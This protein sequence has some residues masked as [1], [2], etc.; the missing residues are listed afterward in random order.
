MMQSLNQQSL[1]GLTLF[2]DL[3][4]TSIAELQN[5][6]HSKKLP[7]ATT[8]LSEQHDGAAVYILLHG[9]VK[10]AVEPSNGTE[11]ILAICGPGEV[12]GEINALDGLGHS[13][14]VVTLE[15]S[16][17]LCIERTAFCHCLRTIPG[18]AFNLAQIQARRLRRISSQAQML[19][20]L[21]IYGRMAYQLLT[22]AKDYGRTLENG[23]V[24]IPIRLT[25]DELAVLIG[26]TRVSV[27]RVLAAHRKSACISINSHHHITIHNQAELLQRLQCRVS[28]RQRPCAVEGKPQPLGKGL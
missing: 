26:A 2:K 14:N 9:T 6:L 19:A 7:A 1:L 11:V 4:P 15:Q 25:Q 5:V 21:D 20:S 24:V 18:L 27:N 3:A 10:I 13:A 28:L 22:F 12:L 16:T 17:F 8:V 23:D